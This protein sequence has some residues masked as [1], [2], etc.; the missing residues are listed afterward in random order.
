[1]AANSTV[2]YNDSYGGN[3]TGVP[4]YACDHISGHGSETVITSHRIYIYAAV[5]FVFIGLV[6]N[7]LSVMVFSSKEMRTV[8]S[9]FYLLTLAISDSLY[10]VS[11]FLTKILT[12][13]RCLY[14]PLSKMDIFN[15]SDFSC[16]LLQYFLDLFSDYSTCLILAFTVERYIAVYMPLKFK[17][18]C[19][20]RRA[21]IVCALLFL[22]SASSIAP[23]H[24]MYIERVFGFDV[25]AVNPEHEAVFSILYILEA[26]TFRI[27]PVFIIATLNVFIIVRVTKL[28]RERRR[29]KQ[30]GNKHQT[31]TISAVTK[32]KVRKE[33]KSMQLTIML[34]L[35][36]TSYILVYLPVLCHFVIWRLKR[37]AII[38]IGEEGLEIAQIYTSALYISGYAI[39]FFLYTMSGRVFREQLE[40]ILCDNHKRDHKNGGT[41]EMTTLV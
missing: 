24:Y 27:I 35:V 28:T 26:L 3:S 21:R 32:K 19:T 37:S 10:L 8:S 5:F 40:L 36:S 22:F 1:M 6:G 17:E 39:N 31:T 4:D 11:V 23:Y 7:A 15:R 9:N 38:N 41:A 16:K 12:A 25:C 14:I 33:D 2:G 20:V 30:Q 34:I 13:F 18:L 29:M